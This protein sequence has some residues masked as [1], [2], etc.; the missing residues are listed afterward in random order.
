VSFLAFMGR[1]VVA[2]LLGVL[3]LF[4]VLT[5][6]SVSSLKEQYDHY[7]CGTRTTPCRVVIQPD[8]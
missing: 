2:I 3:V 7:S 4:Q 5:W 1:H 8:R 6:L